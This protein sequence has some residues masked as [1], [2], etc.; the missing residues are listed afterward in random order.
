MSNCILW[1]G[2]VRGKGYGQQ[3]DVV[4]KRQRGAHVIAWEKA[5]G[6]RVPSGLYVMHRCD[7]K[8]CVNPEHL[9]L[10][11]PSDNVQDMVAKGRQRTGWQKRT[12]NERG[13]FS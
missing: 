8:L 10:G 12:R 1:E 2:A 13:Q 5:N 7:V 9:V 6:R 4:L 11:T 3:W